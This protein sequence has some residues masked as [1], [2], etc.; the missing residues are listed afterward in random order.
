MNDWVVPRLE[1]NDSYVPDRG[2][3]LDAEELEA[4]G[5]FFRYSDEDADH[6][7]PR[8][9]PGVSAKGS[10]FTRGSGHDR[11]GAYT[12]IPD[13]Y[14][15]VMD[16]VAKKHVAAA[17][18]VPEPVILQGDGNSVGIVTVGG[19]DLAVREVVEILGDRGIEVDYM[20]VRAFPFTESVKEFLTAHETLFVVEQN[21][22]AQLRS[23]LTLETPVQKSQLRSIQEYGGFPLSAK[24][25]V[26]GVLSG[27]EID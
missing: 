21:R 2:R 5:T 18:Y 10:F 17:R 1:W 8:T 11:Y 12:E 25:V 24:Q 4:I 6:V 7:T 16:R 15:E 13:E 23:L 27:L 9:L 14:Q 3:V 20:R 19:C 22:D 26:D